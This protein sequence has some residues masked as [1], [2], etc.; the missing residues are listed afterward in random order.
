M[1]YIFAAIVAVLLSAPAH[2]EDWSLSTFAHGPRSNV[3]YASGETRRAP[4]RHLETRRHHRTRQKVQ[5]DEVRFYAAPRE[6]ENC[7]APVRGVGSQWI[8][9]AGA[10]DAAK[11]DWRERVRYD[12]GESFLDMINARDERHRCGRTSIG[13]VAGQVFHRCEIIARPCKA[14]FRGEDGK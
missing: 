1:R 13:E 12:Y 11:K 2:A 8:G 6:A 4:A 9:E 5:R 3:S 7:R 14:E 10:L